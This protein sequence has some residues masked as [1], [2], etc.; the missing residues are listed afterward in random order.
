[1][2]NIK[3]IEPIYVCPD[4]GSENV[5]EPTWVYANELYIGHRIEGVDFDLCEDCHAQMSIITKEEYKKEG[6]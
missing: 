1:M 2:K 6:A 3:Y 4:C 5:L